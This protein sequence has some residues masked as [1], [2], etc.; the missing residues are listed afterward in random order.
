[1]P[2]FAKL[3]A[4]FFASASVA[5]LSYHAISLVLDPYNVVWN[6][7]VMDHAAYVTEQFRY[8]KTEEL[9]HD[10]DRYDTVL[11][12]NSR[13]FDPDTRLLDQSAQPAAF[14]LFGEQRL[15]RGIFDEDCMAGEDANTVEGNHSGPLVRSVSDDRHEL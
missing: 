5:F 12:G 4:A 7:E 6:R 13:A 14:Q 3:V 9:R 8:H 2:Y 15:S 11:L 1:M 10:P